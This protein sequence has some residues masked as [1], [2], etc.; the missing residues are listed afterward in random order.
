MWRTSLAFT[1][2]KPLPVPL[3][4]GG[5]TWLV[6]ANEMWTETTCH[7]WAEVVESPSGLLPS[8]LSASAAT[9]ELYVPDDATTIWLSSHQPGSFIP[10]IPDAPLSPSCNHYLDV[11]KVSHT[12]FYTFATFIFV[13]NTSYCFACIWTLN[14]W[15]LIV[16]ISLLLLFSSYY[17]VDIYPCCYL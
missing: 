14:K 3:K 4:M 6:L 1:T 12:C 17:M 10:L 9:E 16:C 7:F 11:G 15:Y 8:C 2:S 5:A 13:I